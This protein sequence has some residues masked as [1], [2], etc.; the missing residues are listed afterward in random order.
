M[1]LMVMVNGKQCSLNQW[2]A[3]V[4][5]AEPRWQFESVKTQEGSWNGLIVFTY[6][7]ARRRW[8]SICYLLLV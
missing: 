1:T 8:I 2:R 7:D 5:G 3:L 4:R 6:G